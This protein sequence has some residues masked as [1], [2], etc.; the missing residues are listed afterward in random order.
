MSAEFE[1]FVERT[2]DAP[3][4]AVWKAWTEHLAEW[5]APKP[6]TATVIEQDLRA[7]GNR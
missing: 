6:W 7:G 1:L 2:F 5:W 4:W 3:A